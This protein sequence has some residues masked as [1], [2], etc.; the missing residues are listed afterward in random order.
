MANFEVFLWSIKLI[1]NLLFLK[2][3][4]KKKGEILFNDQSNGADKIQLLDCNIEGKLK[5][6]FTWIFFK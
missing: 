5:P 3:V 4:L 1:I 2:N 6:T